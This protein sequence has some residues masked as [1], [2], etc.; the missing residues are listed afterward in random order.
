M[1]IGFHEAES[2]PRW[3]ADDEVELAFEKEW[4]IDVFEDECPDGV[5]V[6]I[7]E[8]LQCLCNDKERLDERG[9]LCIK[10]MLCH[11]EVS[12]QFQRDGFA[13]VLPGKLFRQFN[14]LV[15]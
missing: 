2:N 12:E 11:K 9:I 10:K 7:N 8:V 6:A 4:L 14:R 15:I 3:I 13:L 5:T 1:I